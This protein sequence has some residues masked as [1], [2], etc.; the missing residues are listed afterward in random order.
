MLAHYILPILLAL[1][2]PACER[3]S[4]AERSI[5]G[6]WKQE[7]ID[8]TAY[9]VLNPD[10][11]YAHVAEAGMNFPRNTLICGGSWRVEAQDLI[12]D[13]TVDYPPESQKARHGPERHVDR[14]PII[15]FTKG[16]SRHPAISYERP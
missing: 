1:S 13:C 9:F 5:V 12:R 8:S 10:H 6:T 2:L 16:L 3:L 7:N 11:S 4:P 14:E 15:E